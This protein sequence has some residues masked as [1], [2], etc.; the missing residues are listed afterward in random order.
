MLIICIRTAATNLV[1]TGTMRDSSA[2]GVKPL[3]IVKKHVF[4]DPGKNKGWQSRPELP[5]SSEILAAQAAT[6]ELPEN[7]VDK[8][9]ESKA[10]YLEAHYKILRREGYEGLR[11]SV[12]EYKKSVKQGKEMIDD[13]HTCVYTHVHVKTYL[14]TQLGPIVR[15]EFS[16]RQS[17][18]QIKWQQS[19]RLTPGTIVAITTKADNFGKI[20]KIATVAQRP[21]RDGLDQDPPLV[22]LMWANPEDAVFD[23]DLE[24]VM[25]ESRNGYFESARH[26]LVGLQHAAQTES[27]LDKYLIGA[28]TRD[29]PPSFVL[30][31]PEMDFRSIA[32]HVVEGDLDSLRP[33]RSHNVLTEGITYLKDMTTLDESQL[34]GLRQIV[35]SELAIVQGPPGTGKTFT[36]VQAIKVI[37]ATRQ[38]FGGPPL[39][40]AAQT[41]HA[42]DQLLTHCL[43][44]GANILRVGGRTESPR[45]EACTVYET[46]Q[47][48]KETADPQ[49][50]A[51]SNTRRTIINAIQEL[52]SSIF[53]DRLLSPAALLDAGI[54]SQAQHDSLFD[55]TMDTNQED[56]ERGPL[57]L[58]LGNN[59]IE[60]H[61]LRNKHKSWP[62]REEAEAKMVLGEFE[63]DGDLDNIADDEEDQDRIYGTL[64]GLAH[65]WSGKEPADSSSWGRAV[66][67]QLAENDDLFEIDHDL[68]G[69]V[70]QYFQA[71]LLAALTPKFTTLLAR[72][73]EICKQIKAN[74]WDRDTQLVKMGRIE[75]VGC[76]TTGLTKYRGFLAALKP[77]S[78]LIEEAAETREANIT[79]A[80]YPSLQQLILV[81]DHQQLAPQCDIRWLGDEPFNLNIS[82]FQ[83]MVNLKMPF[84]MLKQQRRMKPELRYI[85]SPFYPELEDHPV[86]LS[87]EN[88]PDVPGMGGRNCFFFDHAWP[89]KIDSDQSKK[90]EQEAQ[91]ITHFFAYLVANDVPASKITVLTFYNGQ[92]KLVLSNLKR[93]PTLIGYQ[94]KVCT[95]DSYQGEENDM[96]LL[97]L[98]RSP[99]PERG[100]DVGFLEDQRRAVVAISR[101]RRGF[102]MFGNVENMLRAHMGSYK[103]WGRIWNGF[104]EQGRVQ[105]KKGL[106]IVCQKHQKELWIR[107]VD[108][109]GDNAGGC[110]MLCKEMRSCGHL[111]TLKCHHLPHDQLLCSQACHKILGCGHGCEGF[112]NQQCSCSCPEFRRIRIQSD[113]ASARLSEAIAGNKMTFEEKLLKSGASKSLIQANMSS[114][115][116]SSIMRNTSDPQDRG[117]QMGGKPLDVQS[118]EAWQHFTSNV[119]AHDE[120]LRQQRLTLSSTLTSPDGTNSGSSTPVIKDIYQPTT[121]VQGR[122]TGNGAKSMQLQ[123][124][125]PQTPNKSG[126]SAQDPGTNIG[127]SALTTLLPIR[128][129]AN[130]AGERRGTTN[131]SSGVSALPTMLPIRPVV[132]PTV[133]SHGTTN[134]NTGLSAMTTLRPIRLAATPAV[135]SYGTYNPNSGVSAQTQSPNPHKSVQGRSP[136]KPPTIP[137]DDDE[138]WLIEL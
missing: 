59:L 120:S 84:V 131:P 7:P 81:G 77:R 70:Y 118:F 125:R 91:M 102:Y 123:S 119:Q 97:S 19:K 65:K 93:Y 42:L 90:N 58:W 108:D 126:Q 39:I 9:W 78:L 21:Y 114:R 121:L 51:F 27:P 83:R 134:P 37:L 72:Y 11:Y 60:A 33:L 113:A 109:W 16:T 44:A 55:D 31:Q 22:D 74:K 112:C 124:S 107:E 13:D 98:V 73:V 54:V 47:R 3:E 122:R 20:C 12:T 29:T 95:V 138:E 61:L 116:L 94:F 48:Y 23:P 28:Y 10:A 14:F 6:E 56:L 71:E 129:A 8:A 62:Q 67:R 24:L 101:A 2:V 1:D 79:S 136:A 17:R 133:K 92:R 117:S 49:H 32:H 4:F 15:V 106:P 35:A 41:N 110:D 87:Y 88:R 127:M 80:I 130:P 132:S 99:Q 63:F 68:R 26:A 76:T 104:A 38:K 34:E 135:E 53:G 115:G 86:V 25:I 40:V 30:E 66:A 100:F 5:E 111:C 137:Q 96:V 52:V 45:V 128:P 43:D 75:V 89:E 46:R 36:S 64:V 85:L 69:V 50:K 57:S 105:R 103:L 18:Y 82:L